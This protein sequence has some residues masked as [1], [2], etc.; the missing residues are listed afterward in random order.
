MLHV[1][2]RIGSAELAPLLQSRGLPVQ[3]RSMAYGDVAFPG[4]GP[5]HPIPIGVERKKVPDVLQCIQDNRFSGHQ[6]PGLL[7]CYQVVYL[8]VEGDYGCGRDGDLTLHGR[9]LPWGRKNWK[10]AALENWLNTMEL[11]AGIHIRRTRDE[12]MTVALIHSL[13]SWW[14]EDWVDHRAHLDFD[15]PKFNPGDSGISFIKPSPVRLVGKEIPGIGWVRSSA[16]DRVFPTVL[17]MAQA[18]VGVWSEIEIQEKKRVRRL[19]DVAGKN[20]Y[21]FFRRRG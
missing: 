16:L 11:R 19:G 18:P 1:D 3:I 6:L 5:D 4:E 8:I 15:E 7:A 12:A 20:A 13:Y 10:Y 9:K 17:Q 2:P 21:D 14:Q